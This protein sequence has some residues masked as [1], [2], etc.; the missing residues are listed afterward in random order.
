MKK[1]PTLQCLSYLHTA[2]ESGEG[3]DLDTLIEG[4][5]VIEGS[6]CV[7]ED[8][9]DFLVLL[10]FDDERSTPHPHAD[11]VSLLTP[12]PGKSVQTVG[13]SREHSLCQLFHGVRLQPVGRESPFVMIL[14]SAVK[15]NCALK[16]VAVK[17]K[18]KQI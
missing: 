2:D 11:C 7:Q 16:D 5:V 13:K 4:A 10:P 14:Q 3:E 12:L 9:G 1:I 6:L 15:Y 17:H 18:Y 8:D